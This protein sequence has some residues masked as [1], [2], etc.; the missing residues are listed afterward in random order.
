MYTIFSIFSLPCAIIALCLISYNSVPSFCISWTLSWTCRG[1]ERKK[2]VAIRS[3]WALLELMTAS[4]DGWGFTAISS[5]QISFFPI[6]KSVWYNMNCTRA[7]LHST[8]LNPRQIVAAVPPLIF[9]LAKEMI[10][11]DYWQK[12]LTG[13]IVQWWCKSKNRH[14]DYL[15]T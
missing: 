9:F 2:E 10:K 6:E 12:G 14:E 8:K 5:Q 15:V 13:H 7:W 3:V 4:Q 1:E 11:N